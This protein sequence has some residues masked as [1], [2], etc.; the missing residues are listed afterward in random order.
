MT[1]GFNTNVRGIKIDIEETLNK[2]LN[3]N[4][5][6]YSKKE[7]DDYLKQIGLDD[8][9]HDNTGQSKPVEEG[10]VVSFDLDGDGDDDNAYGILATGLWE[11][12][13][14]VIQ[15]WSLK[16]LNEHNEFNN[17]KYLEKNFEQKLR[18]NWQT[19][20]I[21]K[22]GFCIRSI[23]CEWSRCFF[24]NDNPQIQKGGDIDYYSKYKKYQTKLQN[25]RNL[26]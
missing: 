22:D 15:E 17:P 25:L 26:L 12:Q 18:N 14:W 8:T 5:N 13:N 1:G 24:L 6:D 20:L 21:L 9:Y 10:F 11:H 3:Q 2:F 16:D 7:F 4:K 23:G 19:K